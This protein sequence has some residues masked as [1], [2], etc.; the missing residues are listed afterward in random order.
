MISR[1][2]RT[3]AALLLVFLA[4]TLAL[5]AIFQSDSTEIRTVDA[6]S[7]N[8]SATSVLLRPP[9]GCLCAPPL[10]AAVRACNDASL[11][12]SSAS[13]SSSSSS[14]SSDQPLLVDV[15]HVDFERAGCGASPAEDAVC[16][17]V[18]DSCRLD[19][20]D[21]VASKFSVVASPAAVSVLSAIRRLADA[22]LQATA[23]SAAAPH[24]AFFDEFFAQTAPV[25]DAAI[26]KAH[27]LSLL[28]G[29]V[30]FFL[31][32]HYASPV[33]FADPLDMHELELLLGTTPPTF[34][35]IGARLKSELLA[36][37]QPPPDGRRPR[38]VFIGGGGGAGKS[39]SLAQLVEM[40]LL[41]ANQSVR[42]VVY[43]NH[44]WLMEQ[45]P[46]FR[47]LT[48]RGSYAAADTLH[49][50]AQRLGEEIYTAA[51][52][53]RTDIVYEGTMAS[54]ELTNRKIA[55]AEQHQYDTAMIG[56]TVDTGIAIRR[57]LLRALA[58][59]RY[60][61]PRTL[62][63]HHRDFSRNWP[64]YCNRVDR[65]WLFQSTR[66][67]V[68]QLVAQSNN[69]NRT[70]TVYTPVALDAFAAKRFVNVDAANVFGLYN[71]IIDEQPAATASGERPLWSYDQPEAA[72][73]WRDVVAS[74]QYDAQHALADDG[75]C[76]PTTRSVPSYLRLVAMYESHFRNRTVC[77]CS[78]ATL[79]PTSGTQHQR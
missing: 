31:N 59:K 32:M 18:D 51:L 44:D 42:G 30:A 49:P 9:C 16:A 15:V 60:V 33:H 20:S 35:A 63:Q 37:A 56:I 47:Q 40:G 46:L 58:S 8:S 72:S 28:R 7:A 27:W 62:K 52:L 61:R 5:I 4:L 68:A 13:S 34:D 26:S 25:F 2:H 77:M 39:S 45:H 50:A 21:Y 11:T 66:G 65:C 75:R 55:L 43:I 14:S 6:S 67:R 22:Y 3:A 17:L 38:V 64:A 53:A 69:T 70:R 73:S 36:F 24:L 1:R 41:P 48:E 12:S 19:F 78:T 54:L 74:L 29:A 76:A 71:I 57:C 23:A 10:H 79:S